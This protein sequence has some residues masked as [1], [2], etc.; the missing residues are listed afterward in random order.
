MMRPF[1]LE[2]YFAKH[3]F[4]APHLLSSSDCDGWSQK[5]LLSLADAETLALWDG[6]ALGYTQSRGLPLLRREIAKQYRGVS[7]EQ[8]LV[9][10]PQELIFLA[11][12]ALLH[13]GDRIA[14]TFPGYQSLYEVAHA[15]G[16]QV[17]RWEPDE[18]RGWRFDPERLAKL[19]TPRTKLVVVNFPHNPTGALP[20]KE[21]F[22]EIVR[23]TKE[24]SI[25]L[26]S[27]EMY[28]NL[29]HDEA[30][31]LP[32]A[33]ELDDRALSLSGM[34]K[35]FGLAGL[36]I[37]WLVAKDPEVYR[38]LTELKDYTTIC[39]AG[40]AEL[41]ALAGLR[42]RE[43]ILARHRSRIA[44]NLG[45]LDAFF[46]RRPDFTWIRPKAGTV[47]FAG[48][49]RKEPVAEFCDRAVREAGV[50]VLPSTMYEYD[51]P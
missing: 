12:S 9:A 38:R 31:R 51:A 20:S 48:Y 14:C 43:T 10:A 8:V 1:L 15:T 50:M 30:D 33:C 34:S 29:E 17:D 24:R 4:T 3:E 41:L 26:F 46:R 45:V 21:D 18:S 39:S 6:L 36:R 35:S 42:A 13:K 19:L 32:A 7:E 2:R 5:E 37:G 22:A 27:D 16:C 23:L 28:R 40:P 25:P 47:G 49:N 11:M 44:R